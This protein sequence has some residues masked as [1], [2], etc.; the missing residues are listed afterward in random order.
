MIHS[1]IPT[2]R[3]SGLPA[4]WHPAQVLAHSP[5]PRGERT[6]LVTSARQVDDRSSGKPFDSDDIEGE[7][8]QN[9][10]LGRL[11]ILADQVDLTVRATTMVKAHDATVGGRPGVGAYA[12]KRSK[13][14][15]HRKEEATR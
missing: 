12:E 1:P 7:V 10:L 3:W 9:R 4:A 15:G 11:G 13:C 5:E 2:G 8:V 14:T 6:A